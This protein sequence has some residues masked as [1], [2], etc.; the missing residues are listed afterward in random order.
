MN[1]TRERI[2]WLK[3]TQDIVLANGELERLTKERGVNRKKTSIINHKGLMVELG[4]D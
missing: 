2:Q 3:N 4:Q 1:V